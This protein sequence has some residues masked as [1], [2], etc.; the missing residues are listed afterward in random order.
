MNSPSSSSFVILDS[1]NGLLLTPTVVSDNYLSENETD[2]NTMVTR[3]KKIFVGGLSANTTVDDVKKY[4]E[5]Y[6]KVEDAMLMFD[7]A[8]Q[9]H[10]GF[11]FVTFENEDVVDKVCDI[12]FHEINNKMV[13]CKKAQPK[14]VMY[15]QQMAKGKAALQRGV[16]GDL[17]SAYVYGLNRM[18]ATY[19]APIYPFSPGQTAISLHQQHNLYGTDVA[20]FHNRLPAYFAAG[21]PGSA[22]ISYIP[23]GA[24]Q[25]PTLAPGEQRYFEYPI[26]TQQLQPGRADAMALSNAIHRETLL[27]RSANGTLDF[28]PPDGTTYLQ[29][30]SP[31][32]T[33]I[34]LATS[35]IGAYANGFHG[36]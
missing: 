23:A 10:R 21:I 20:R 13:E 1:S 4:F 27:Q 31:T 7:K 26:T 28:F 34:P 8:T 33:G 3:T 24:L 32:S 2:T 19:A 9:R 15:A 6:G 25:T 5:Q 22:Q 17:L 11:G 35:L 18:P 16:Y 30:T 12:H 29:P 14:E 36:H